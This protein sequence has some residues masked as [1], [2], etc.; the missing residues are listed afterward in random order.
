MDGS[1]MEPRRTVGSNCGSMGGRVVRFDEGGGVSMYMG[2]GPA[3][4]AGGLGV[5][6][7]I[8]CPARAHTMSVQVES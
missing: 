2:V 1:V 6:S 3:F 5:V 7:F 8:G 4:I